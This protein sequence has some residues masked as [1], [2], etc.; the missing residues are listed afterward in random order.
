[1]SSRILGSD[2]RNVNEGGGF[3]G[4]QP[5][6]DGPLPSAPPGRPRSRAVVVT[7][8]GLFPLFAAEELLQ[9]L[10]M[11]REKQPVLVA[12]DGVLRLHDVEKARDGDVA[13]LEEP[14]I[15]GPDSA[16]VEMP[17]SWTL[18]DY[19]AFEYM[20]MANVIQPGL[21]AHSQISGMHQVSQSISDFD[22]SV[23]DFGINVY[24]AS[25]DVAVSMTNSGARIACRCG[26][27]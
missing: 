5:S 3:F 16:L 19:P 2:R 7:G 4:K 25:N 15:F 22:K 6:A 1:M 24:A 18:D 14:M 27:L 12:A 20:R 23:R 10:A 11:R 21:M 8:F 17:I 9:C 26:L 13:K